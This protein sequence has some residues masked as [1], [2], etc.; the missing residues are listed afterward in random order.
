MTE[1]G[2]QAPITSAPV[3]RSWIDPGGFIAVSRTAAMRRNLA[4]DR[5]VGEG[6][7]A[8]PRL[9]AGPTRGAGSWGYYEGD[10]LHDD[11]AFG[12][13]C[14]SAAWPLPTSGY[15]A[16]PISGLTVGSLLQIAPT[17]NRPPGTRDLPTIS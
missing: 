7:L 5:R 17:V 9:C 6:P 11:S 12:A 3:E 8:T 4:V 10:R 16:W 2:Q 1:K 15:A 13:A 14:P